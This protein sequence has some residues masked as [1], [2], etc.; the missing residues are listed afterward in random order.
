MNE[1]GARSSEDTNWVGEHPV[2]SYF[3][4]S[5]AI[6]WLAALSVALPTLLSRR[7][8]PT[9]TGVQTAPA[10]DWRWDTLHNQFSEAVLMLVGFHLAIN[11]EWILAAGQKIFRRF[12]DGFRYR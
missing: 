1:P 7:R 2:I 12:L 8:I 10:L 11:W 3:L 4:L 6:S 5:F 9:L